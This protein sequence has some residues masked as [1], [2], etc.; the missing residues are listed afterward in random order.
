[1]LVSLESEQ[2]FRRCSELKPVQRALLLDNIGCNAQ[3]EYGRRYGFDDIKS[4][5]DFRRRVPLVSYEDIRADVDRMAAGERNVLT[6]ERVLA[7]FKTSGSL[8]APKLVPVTPSLVREKARAFGVFWQE[9]YKAHPSLRS[10]R[11]IANFTDSGQVERTGGGHDVLSE[12]TFWGRR[13]HGLHAR[14]R[15]PVPRELRFVA[16]HA[17]RHYAAARLILQGPLHGMMCLNPSTLLMF[18]RIIEERIGQLLGG[19]HDGDWG[20]TD[21]DFLAGLPAGL[22]SHLKADKARARALSAAME[23]GPALTLKRFWPTLEQAICWRSQIVQPYYRQL[24][25]YL[26]GI[27][28]RDYITQSSE[29]IMAIAVQDRTSGGPLAYQSHFFEFIPDTEIEAP[30]PGTCFGWELEQG[31]CYEPVV[32]TGGGLYRYR[33]GDCIRVNGFQAQVPIIEFLYRTGRTSS[34][35]GEK[36]TEFQ[37][38]EAVRRTREQCGS[39]PREVLCFPR[40]GRVPHYALLLNWM[41]ERAPADVAAHRH[42]I[43][44]WIKEFDCQLSRL[45]QEYGDKCASGR[46]GAITGLIAG[47]RGFEEYRRMRQA[48]SVSDAQRKSEVLNAGL[49]LDRSITIMDIVHAN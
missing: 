40:S 4:P 36:L 29:C 22:S 17:H 42:A 27:D 46:L 34:M 43:R 45:N 9:V 31:R 12:A 1:M 30:N 48:A 14:E 2:F 5:D 20:R 37:V 19:L 16:D 28:E 41:D 33:T 13:T 21:D 49:D 32:T 44:Q 15:W 11:V 35:T 7:F 47:G 25:P 18:C 23:P 3:C 8:A 6:A 10:G 39:A 38:S 26:E 24:A